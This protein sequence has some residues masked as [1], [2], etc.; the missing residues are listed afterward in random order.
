M[1][2][3][4]EMKPVMAVQRKNYQFG[5]RAGQSGPKSTYKCRVIGMEEDTFNVGASSDPAKFSKSLKSIEN[6][7]KKTYK[8]PN[9]I[10]KAIQQM[11][12][13][14]LSYPNKPTKA[15]CVDDQGNFDEDKFKMAKFT[16]KKDYKDVRLKK[17]KYSNNKLNAWALINDKCAPEL[18]NKLEGTVDYNVCKKTNDVVSLLS[19]IQGYCCQFDTLNDEY[20]SI[21]GAIKNL[22]YLF[23]KLTQASS[24]YH[25]DFMAMVKV[26]K[27]T[28]ELG[29]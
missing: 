12:Q 13:L 29:C 10:V 1:M 20:M 4:Q 15:K 9:D 17:D 5:N 7:I 25:E 22:L 16:W 24:D 23:Q 28:E 18:K 6:Y 2:A 11:K 27:N 3:E 8:M 21:V 19:M 26:I 14:T